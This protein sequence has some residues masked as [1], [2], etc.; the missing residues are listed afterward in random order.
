MTR[1]GRWRLSRRHALLP[2]LPRTASSACSITPLL[3]ACDFAT[4][5]M[6]RPAHIQTV[7]IALARH[8]RPECAAAIDT[9]TFAKWPWRSAAYLHLSN[10]ICALA[11]Y[12]RLKIPPAGI[13]AIF[14]RLPC[15]DK[16]WRYSYFHRGTR[17]PKHRS[18]V[19]ERTD[20]ANM[21]RAW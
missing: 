9:D 11:A 16:D 7:A 13:L 4:L 10:E 18:I 2:V 12:T 5:A 6:T 15:D 19:I 8:A 21:H 3:G 14:S 20:E 1:S 17:R